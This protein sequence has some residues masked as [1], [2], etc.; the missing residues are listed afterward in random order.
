MIQPFEAFSA[1][2][3]V[4]VGLALGLTGAGGAILLMPLMVYG[5]G[6]APE[7]AAGQS[8]AILGL[9]GAAGA[10]AST[11]RGDLL[12][13]EFF[14][15]LPGVVVGAWAGRAVLVEALPA[16]LSLAGQVWPRGSYLMLALAAV[17]AAAAVSLLRRPR[18]QAGPARHWIGAVAGLVVGLLTGVLGAGGGFLLVPALVLASRLEPRQAAGTSLGLVAAG[19]AVAGATE[20]ARYWP[21]ARWP[22]L[23]LLAAGSGAGMALGLALRS[24]TPQAALRTIMAVLIALVALGIAARE[25]LP[26]LGP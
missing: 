13:A 15:Y 7:R 22:V 10:V 4:L 19:T 21:E 23:A 17:M 11:R 5:L 12:P 2:A 16:E 20:L 25:V 24:R 6:I 9:V 8:A 18:P 1:A 26:R 14:R 3:S